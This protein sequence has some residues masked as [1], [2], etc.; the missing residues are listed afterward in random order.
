MRSRDKALQEGHLAVGQLAQ[1]RHGPVAAR[2]DERRRPLV[3]VEVLDDRSDLRHELHR[4]G[5]GAHDADPLARQVEAVLPAGGVEDL[6]AEVLQTR[7]G[8]DGRA[9]S[10]TRWPTPG[11]GPCTPLP[12]WCGR[13]SASAASSQRA[14]STA[15]PEAQGTADV[16]AVDTLAH[17]VPDLALRGER[18]RDQSGFER[19]GEG[20]EVG[21]DVAGR[22]RGTSC[23]ARYR[24]GRCRGRARRSRRCPWRGGGPPCRC[25]RTRHRRRRRCARRSRGGGDEG[26]RRLRPALRR[27]PPAG[28]ARL[29]RSSC[30]AAPWPRRSAP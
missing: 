4:R 19:E 14:S 26:Q 7:E 3:Q 21:G 11:P 6:A 1:A 30:G 29:R 9:R 28:S 8:R 17:V 5:S 18:A 24:R 16:E 10:A 20:V 13:P 25:R 22:R 23:R 2:D 15:P 12:R 27:S